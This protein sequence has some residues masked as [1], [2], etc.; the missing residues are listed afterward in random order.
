MGLFD[1]VL[2]ELGQYLALKQAGGGL[3]ELS[4]ESQD[5]WPLKN[6]P[7][8]KEETAVQLGGKGNASLFMMLWDS[9]N[10]GAANRISLLGPD[11]Q[12]ATPTL[13][14]GLVIVVK[15]DFEEAYEA[16]RELRS[17][18]YGTQPLGLS[19]RIRP[20]RSQIWCRISETAMQEGFSLS[21]YGTLLVE[22]LKKVEPVQGVEVLFVTRSKE[23]V[24]ELGP[25]SAKAQTIIEAMVKMYEEMNFECETCDYNDICE[26]V[27][28]LKAMRE[29]LRESG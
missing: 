4:V 19:I 12:S 14:L 22:R 21:T 27:V 20:D 3:R 24:A 15:G 16:Y 8:L 25:I 13:P 7:V 6:S 11:V 10:S 18:A 9:N 1:K 23:D 5:A 26:E 2:V 28:E 29:S 17:A